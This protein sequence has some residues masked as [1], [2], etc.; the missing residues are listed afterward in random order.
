MQLHEPPNRAESNSIMR[1]ERQDGT[2]QQLEP[3]IPSLP[4][5]TECAMSKGR[6]RRTS[7]YCCSRK[8]CCCSSGGYK[9]FMPVM[10]RMFSMNTNISVVWGPRRA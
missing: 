6:T 5:S 4:F 3:I 1:S 2:P 7:L 10:W 9:A 8:R